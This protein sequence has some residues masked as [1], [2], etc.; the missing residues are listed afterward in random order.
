MRKNL[1][2]PIHIDDL[3]NAD[4]SSD[5]PEDDPEEIRSDED[6]GEDEPETDEPESIA[7]VNPGRGKS[8][9]IH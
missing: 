6:S 9:N 3:K 4:K 7:I 1:G 2:K 5:D 8:P